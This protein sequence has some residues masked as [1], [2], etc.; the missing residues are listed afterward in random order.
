MNKKL[1]YLQ[2]R[3]EELEKNEERRIEMIINEF[4][5]TVLKGLLGLLIGYLIWGMK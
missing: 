2:E 3:V 1:T 5:T 4:I